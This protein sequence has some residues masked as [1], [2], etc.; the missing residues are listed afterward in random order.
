[1][2]RVDRSDTT[3]S[4]KT[5]VKERLRCV[6]SCE[7]SYLSFFYGIFFFFFF[8]FY[9]NRW[10]IRIFSCVVGAFTNIQVHIHNDTQTR[11]NNLFYGSH[12]ELLRAGIESGTRCAVAS[13]PATAPTVPSAVHSDT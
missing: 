11:N 4:Q 5:D 1:M 10:A 2:G 8:L 9:I 3:A 13:C 12:K 6:S 7:L